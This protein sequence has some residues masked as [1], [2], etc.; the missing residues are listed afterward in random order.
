MI[1]PM[2]IDPRHDDLR[3]GE[4]LVPVQHRRSD[5]ASLAASSPTRIDIPEMVRTA[6][7]TLRP[8]LSIDRGPFLELVRTSW[9]HLSP[10]VPL[11]ESGESDDAFFDRQVRLCAQG[12]ADGS[13][14]RRVGVLDDGGLVGMFNLNAISR[15][16]SWE[17]DAAWWL[18]VD[19]LG[20][21][22][23]SEGVSAMLRHALTPAPGG[24]GL[25]GVHCGIA[26]LN[27]ASRRVAER[28]GFVHQPGKHSYLKVGGR[29]AYHEFFLCSE[30]P[31]T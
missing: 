4:V 8:L 7:L 20:R 18:G 6:R 3:P 2:A 10:W 22:L 19:H 11:A 26:P 12:D 21:G 28:C 23:A 9:E 5:V 30:P 14:W 15:G 13:A 24:L 31:A 29:W 25:F 17:A 16:L 27:E 1:E